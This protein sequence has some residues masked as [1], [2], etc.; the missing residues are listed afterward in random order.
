MQSMWIRREAR[1][2]GEEMK[3]HGQDWTVS[4]IEI[5]KKLFE[6]G[7]DDRTIGEILGRNNNAIRSKRQK[8]GLL[9]PVAMSNPE[10]EIKGIHLCEEL[11]DIRLV[12]IDKLH[13]HYFD[14]ETKYGYQR[15]PKVALL[16][17]MRKEGFAGRL[18]QVID[19]VERKWQNGDIYIVDGGT[20]WIAAKEQGRTHMLCKFHPE[21]TTYLDEPK[22]FRDLNKQR[23]SVPSYNEFEARLQYEEPRAVRIDKLITRCGFTLGTKAGYTVLG[24]SA[25]LEELMSGNAVALEQSLMM[26]H[27]LCEH[28]HYPAVE[29]LVRGLYYIA[30]NVDAEDI[31]ARNT[32]VHKRLMTVGAEMLN[33]YCNEHANIMRTR[34]TKTMG[35]AILERINYRASD[36][37][38][39]RYRGTKCG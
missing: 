33:K 15:R 38:K 22:L 39:I 19:V 37:N 3:N 16:A 21:A 20:R 36:R 24:G 17:R 11:V 13:V 10:I 28:E 34:S 1:Q 14:P 30:A 25:R 29:G 4:E 31:F 6:K 8:L 26:L 27:D 5:L 12:P 7:Q 9:L 2:E 23:G 35:D 18:S 32:W